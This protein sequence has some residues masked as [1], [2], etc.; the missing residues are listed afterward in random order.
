MIVAG[1]ALLALISAGWAFWYF[2]QDRQ[3]EQEENAQ[4]PEAVAVGETLSYQKCSGTGSGTLT[5]LPMNQDDFAF[6]VPYGLVIG[7]HVTPIDHQYYSPTVFNSPRDTYPVYAMANAHIVD[8]QSR[9]SGRGVEYRMVF[10]MSCT[11]FYYYDL[12]TSL[13]P[14]IKTEYDSNKNSQGYASVDIPV[15][16]GQEIGKIG[17]QTLD[18]AVWDTTKPLS[19]FVNPESY[20][21]ELWKIYTADPLDYVTQDIREVMIAKY[22]RTAE[23]ISG[24]IDHDIDG[25]LIGNWFLEGTD[26]YA[27]AGEGNY[28]T[29]HLSIAPEHLDPTAYIVSFGNYQGEAEQFSIPRDSASPSEV[30]TA[31][32]L[33]KYELRDWE[34]L[35]E[36]GKGWDRDSLA[37][38]LKLNNSKNSGQGCVLFELIEDQKLKMEAFP[39]KKCSQV[40]KFTSAAKFYTR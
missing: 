38:N 39:G 2:R 16:A 37:K 6:I 22:L 35:K 26:G 3:N 28:W 34:Y 10:T 8:I 27:G 23:P 32:G 11:F 20:E 15:K 12:V 24:K 7:A 14:D 21:T 40:K 36:N 1:V 29:S 5:A 19:G 33:V 30:S 17:G 25:R 31:T 13:A 18:F 9:A 4:N